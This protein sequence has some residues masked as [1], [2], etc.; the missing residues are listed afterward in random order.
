MSLLRTKQQVAL[1]DLLIASKDS[2]DHYRDAAAFLE[3]PGVTDTLCQIADQRADLIERLELAIRDTGDLPSAP[4]ADLEDSERLFHRLRAALSPDE[5]EAVLR[6]R[7]DAEQHL[8]HL[9]KQGEKAGLFQPYDTLL[10]ELARHIE[11][12]TER[13]QELLD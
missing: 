9:V 5:T 3:S 13:L 12:V 10:N 11:T 4:D 7:L 1:Q 6:Q 2:V 8:M